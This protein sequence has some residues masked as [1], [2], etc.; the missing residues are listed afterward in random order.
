MF[1]WKR[2][3]VVP[4]RKRAIRTARVEPVDVGAIGQL[5]DIG[6]VCECLANDTSREGSLLRSCV[7]FR[8]PMLGLGVTKKYANSHPVT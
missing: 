6:G 2:K 1:L 7:G 8:P 5:E 4:L 3:N